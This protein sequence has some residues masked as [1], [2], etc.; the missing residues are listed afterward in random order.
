MY[1]TTVTGKIYMAVTK[2]DISDKK[3]YQWRY[4]FM[5]PFHT[6]LSSPY[7]C[8]EQKTTEKGLGLG[9]SAYEHKTHLFTIWD[10]GDFNIAQ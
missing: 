10:A 3:R 7:Q 5:S 6:A 8:T 1:K 4:R 2:S 9:P